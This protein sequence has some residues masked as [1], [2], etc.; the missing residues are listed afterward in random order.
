[1]LKLLQPKIID[2]LVKG[3]LSGDQKRD[4]MIYQMLPASKFINADAYLPAM[5]IL[6]AAT[7]S[8]FFRITPLFMRY[9]SAGWS[10]FYSSWADSPGN[11]FL[12]RLSC[13]DHWD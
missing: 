3:P 5:A 11:P 12:Q 4:P 9:S 10:P 8:P 2:G 7:C 6:M 13:L 1:M